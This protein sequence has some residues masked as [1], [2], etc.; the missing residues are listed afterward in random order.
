MMKGISD[1]DFWL[2]FG[3]F[4]LA[5]V[6][7]GTIAGEAIK[8]FRSW[9]Q[10]AKTKRPAKWQVTMSDPDG[11]PMRS[12]SVSAEGIARLISN[13]NSGFYK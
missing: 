4:G 13:I 5:S 11:I 1:A 12:D 3:L 9:R 10:G 8:A 7:L 2:V 6:G